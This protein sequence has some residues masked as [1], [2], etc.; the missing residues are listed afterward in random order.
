MIKEVRQLQSLNRYSTRST[1][2]AVASGQR[3]VL[4]QIPKIFL[5]KN[6]FVQKLPLCSY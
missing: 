1:G 2:K 4:L 3:L 6:I 5:I